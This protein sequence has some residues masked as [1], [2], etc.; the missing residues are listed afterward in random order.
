MACY[1]ALVS[2]VGLLGPSTTCSSRLLAVVPAGLQHSLTRGP[3]RNE[4]NKAGDWSSFPSLQSA[5]ENTVGNRVLMQL[6]ALMMLVS[7]QV[8]SI[9]LQIGAYP[10]PLVDTVESATIG[11]VRARQL[12][13]HEQEAN[14]SVVQLEKGYI[15]DLR[16][17]EG[18]LKRHP[19]ARNP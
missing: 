13:T 9:L 5:K 18:I 15:A 10:S 6:P 4:C 2:L 14:A 19:A 11:M 3:R 12:A 7:L 16:E 8:C 1:I 17:A